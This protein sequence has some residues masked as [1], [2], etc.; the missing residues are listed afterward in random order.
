M[1]CVQHAT[2]AASDIIRGRNVT[3]ARATGASSL[4]VLSEGNGKE[5]S[6]QE[7]RTSTTWH[8]PVLSYS[9]QQRPVLSPLPM[10]L[11]EER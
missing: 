8:V 4:L 3:V 1:G 2:M 7:Y 11:R 6:P 9:A 5:G 10:G